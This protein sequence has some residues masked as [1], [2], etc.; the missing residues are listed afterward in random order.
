MN[1]ETCKE[2]K[3]QEPVPYRVHAED[4]ARLERANKRL[5]I[6]LILVIVFLC[7]SNAAWIWY[8]SQ[9]EDV[10]VTQENEDGYNSFIGNDGDIFNYGQTN[11]SETDP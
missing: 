2:R 6:L 1:C 8:E 5:W 7:A 11:D 3:P 10:V 9:F 4:M